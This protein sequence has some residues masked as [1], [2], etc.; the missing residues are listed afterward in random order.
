M[1]LGRLCLYRLA[2]CSLAPYNFKLSFSEFP[3][4]GK[5]T[6][7]GRAILVQSAGAVSA[8]TRARIYCRLPNIVRRAEEEG[9]VTETT[10]SKRAGK[11]ITDCSWIAVN[12]HELERMVVSGLRG[13]VLRVRCRWGWCNRHLEVFP[14]PN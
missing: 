12:D 14:A 4:G 3:S 8:S 6:L 13:I 7:E 5:C 10:P 11:K 1:S 9:R 2:F